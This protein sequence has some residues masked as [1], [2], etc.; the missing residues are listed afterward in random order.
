VGCSEEI[1][2]REKERVLLKELTTPSIIIK[3]MMIKGV[4]QP[5]NFS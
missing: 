3:T 1:E 4:F 2:R 5:L